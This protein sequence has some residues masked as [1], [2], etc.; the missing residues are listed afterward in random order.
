M[1]PLPV[2]VVPIESCQGCGACCSEQGA[3]PDYVALRMSP[4]LADDPSFA[5][6]LARSRSLSGEPLRLLDLYFEEREAGR[7][8]ENGVCVWFDTAN[9]CC[10]FYDL[11]PSTCRVFELDSPGCHIYRRRQ[12]IGAGQPSTRD[13]RPGPPSPAEQQEPLRTT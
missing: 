12:G 7:R 1:T 9:C 4:H 11:R 6:D 10:R 2:V 13:L 3:P 5:D 8:S